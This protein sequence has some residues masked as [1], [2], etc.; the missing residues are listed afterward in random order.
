MCLPRFELE[1]L[2]TGQ[3][4]RGASAGVEHCHQTTPTFEVYTGWD[5]DLYCRL[6]LNIK[7]D[8]DAVTGLFKKK[9]GNNMCGNDVNAIK[10][11]P[12]EL[13][14]Y[15]SSLSCTS[16]FCM[17]CIDEFCM[18]LTTENEH[19][20]AGPA[21]V[22]CPEHMGSSLIGPL[23]RPVSTHCHYACMQIYTIDE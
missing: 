2:W 4:L 15:T 3:G 8:V 21:A 12:D 18:C 22:K 1:R 5:G 10:P 16:P 19:C 9:D 17:W 11:T 13:A 23:P 6:H 14:P 20:T 7:K